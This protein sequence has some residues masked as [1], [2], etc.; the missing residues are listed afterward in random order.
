MELKDAT[1]CIY[2]TT[3]SNTIRGEAYAQ[4]H[5]VIVA[6]YS[7]TDFRIISVTSD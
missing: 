2:I 3:T 4:L 5:T 7:Y 1:N 6:L